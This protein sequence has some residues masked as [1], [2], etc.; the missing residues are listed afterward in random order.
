MIWGVILFLTRRKKKS[1]MF[2]L[3]SWGCRKHRLHLCRGVRPRSPTCPGYDTKQSDGKFPVIL[4]LWRM[5]STSLLPSLPG[6]HRLRV[7]APDM[8]LSMGQIDLN[9]VLMLKLIFW[10]RSAFDI[11]PLL[12]LNWIVLNR[13]VL[14]F[15]CVWTKLHL[16]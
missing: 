6:P 5:W 2:C 14:T 15:D 4:D 16:Y 10:N 13:T 7:V 8:A 12:P 3:V 11:E 9:C 1:S